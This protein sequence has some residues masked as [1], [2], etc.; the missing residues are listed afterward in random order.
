V[1]T[2][3]FHVVLPLRRPCPDVNGAEGGLLSIKGSQS[4]TVSVYAS[5]RNP[6]PTSS[7]WAPTAPRSTCTTAPRS[8]RWVVFV[9]SNGVVLVD[10]HSQFSQLLRGSNPS[11]SIDHVLLLLAITCPHL[12]VKEKRRRI[13][14]SDLC[15]SLWL[16]IADP[17][18]HGPQCA[19]RFAVVEPEPSQLGGPRRSHPQP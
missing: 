6:P 7:P 1:A 5:Y 9:S 13:K 17:Y 8:R 12:L 2:C 4:L 10:L 19:R 16:P 14:P 15:G 3:T 18:L 11:F